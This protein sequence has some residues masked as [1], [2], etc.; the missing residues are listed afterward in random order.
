MADGNGSQSQSQ[1][2][3]A[4]QMGFGQQGRSSRPSGFADDLPGA[5]ANAG[6]AAAQPDPAAAG[7]STASGQG[8]V[9]RYA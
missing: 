6:G 4:A 2:G 1:S 3:I 7:R 8:K 9:D 5:G